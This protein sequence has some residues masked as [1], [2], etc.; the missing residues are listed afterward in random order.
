MKKIIRSSVSIV[1]IGNF[2]LNI[3]N[4]QWL[5][6]KQIIAKEDI[7][8]NI[9][10]IVVDENKVSIDVPNSYA[11]TILPN[12]LEVVGNVNLGEQIATIVYNILCHRMPDNID[13]IGLNGLAIYELVDKD[14]KHFVSTYLLQSN[15]RQ[16]IDAAITTELSLTKGSTKYKASERTENTNVKL[17]DWRDNEQPEAH[18]QYSFNDHYVFDKDNIDIS[19]DIVMKLNETR[20]CRFDAFEKL[21]TYEKV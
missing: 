17:F 21:F 16:S 12:R 2:P 9:G 10:N 7:I 15:L 19:K 1:I 18:V 4:L 14:C 3:Y 5:A 8:S 20:A 11:I 6:N 13:A